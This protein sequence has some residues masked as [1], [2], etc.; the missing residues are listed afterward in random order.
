MRFDCDDDLGGM[1]QSVTRT[2][3]P[4]I[5]WLRSIGGARR[6]VGQLRRLNI[7]QTLPSTVVQRIEHDQVRCRNAACRYRDQ[8]AG[9]G[10]GERHL[11]RLINLYDG[12]RALSS[13]DQL[14]SVD[15]ASRSRARCRRL[16][17][18]LSTITQCPALCDHLT[19]TSNARPHQQRSP[20]A[21]RTL[22]RATIAPA[23]VSIRI[24]QDR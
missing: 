20:C 2:R 3:H 1:L 9:T 15:P 7:S 6:R 14:S 19:V 16:P 18:R 23:S 12:F 10:A 8:L 17:S 24:L 4:S 22:S 13:H 11:T 21:N 5:V